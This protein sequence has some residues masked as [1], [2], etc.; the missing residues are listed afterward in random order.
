MLQAFLTMMTKVIV[1]LVL[2]AGALPA[3]AQGKAGPDLQGRI[4][5]IRDSELL[6][7][8]AD[9]RLHSC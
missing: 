6:V 3:L 8:G 5:E 7:R 4:E 9:G 2:L 1:A